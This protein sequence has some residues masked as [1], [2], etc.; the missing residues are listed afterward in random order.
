MDYSV[1]LALREV[2][3]TFKGE[4]ERLGL[5]NA[6]DV[7]HPLYRNGVNIVQEQGN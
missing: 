1:M 3:D 4:V 5:K 2:Q 6:E 7:R